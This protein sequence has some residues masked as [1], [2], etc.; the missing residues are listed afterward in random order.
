MKHP[1]F[2]NLQYY[3]FSAYGFLKNLR[4]FDAFFILFL[5]GQGLSYTQIGVLYALREITI[6]IAEIPS[7]MIA[8]AFGRKRSLIMS[9]LSYI[10]SFMI[11]Y[12]SN[13]FILYLLGFVLFGIGEAFRSGTHKGM[14]M[15]YLKLKGWSDQKMLYYGHT[16]A[17]SQ[18]GMAVSSLLAGL[19]VLSGGGYRNIFLFST[20]PYVVNIFLIFSYPA[21]LDDVRKPSKRAAFGSI[22]RSF[23]QTIKNYQTLKLISYSALHTAYLKAI[24]DYIQPLMLQVAL[25]IPLLSNIDRE[26]QNGLMIGVFFF[27]IFIMTSFVSRSA[28]SLEGKSKKNIVLMTVLWGFAAGILSGILYQNG[29]MIPALLSF[30]V[31]YLV[32]NIRKPIMTA[33]VA[34]HVP[35]EILSSVLSAQSLLKTIMT[36]GIALIFGALAD[37]FGIARSLYLTSIL[38]SL[39]LLLLNFLYSKTRK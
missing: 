17:W 15:S 20:L 24:K 23:V 36:A 29:L 31:I 28:S 16:R 21:E 32:E 26:Q 12:I 7:G 8:D 3:K 4:F 6:N 37:H 34:D 19:I 5:I 13:N 2:R 9:F 27:I 38:L 14:I 18:R 10:I 35:V 30:V 25:L 1:A 11:F 22:F 39:G 33:Y